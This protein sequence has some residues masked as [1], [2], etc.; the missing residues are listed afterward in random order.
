MQC[1]LPSFCDFSA[2]ESG[3]EIPPGPAPETILLNQF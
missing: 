2:N 1:R 3:P